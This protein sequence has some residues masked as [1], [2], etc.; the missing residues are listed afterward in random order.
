MNSETLLEVFMKMFLS[1]ERSQWSEKALK[2][3][4]V[5]VLTWTHQGWHRQPNHSGQEAALRASTAP[6]KADIRTGHVLLPKRGDQKITGGPEEE[7]PGCSSSYPLEYPKKTLEVLKQLSQRLKMT[8][9]L[10]RLG[11]ND[12]KEIPY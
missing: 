11:P 8:A 4:Q 9:G 3:E 7:L 2:N 1:R 5:K 12:S 10:L 6:R